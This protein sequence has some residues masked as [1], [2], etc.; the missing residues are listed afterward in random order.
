[1]P[2]P[3]LP[4]QPRNAERLLTALILVV[5][6]YL[7]ATGAI[8]SQATEKKY[9]TISNAQAR[10]ML[11]NIE[12]DIKE[13]YY[14]PKL[15]G[16]DLE[17]RFDEARQK[18]AAAQSQD[19]AFLI[20]ASAVGALRDSHTHFSPPV[21]PY[22]VD[23]G[24]VMQGVGDS[25]CYV[26]AVRPESDAAA[27]GLKSG[28]LML[29]IN[30]VPLTPESIRSIEFGYRVFPQSGFHLIV[31]S[32]DGVERALVAMSKVIPGQVMVS[33]SDVLAWA[34]AYRDSGERDRSRYHEVN[35]KVLFL[36]A[37]RFFDGA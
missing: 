19:D 29:S 11:D 17:K 26:T 1:M 25:A 6:A 3:S 27:K 32:P 13:N 2:E 33:H 7:A 8:R 18:I 22:G 23:Y 37:P 4:G 12:A 35:K 16:L 34:R 15:H 5:L 36:G 10:E 24:W 21:R 31:R 30:G 20:I 14:D 9:A 28:D